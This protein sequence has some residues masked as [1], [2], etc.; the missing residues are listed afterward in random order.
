MGTL[1]GNFCA[2]KHD[3]HCSAG[4]ILN[5]NGLS[6]GEM[7]P[8]SYLGLQA[9]GTQGKCAQKCYESDQ[10]THERS[11]FKSK[12]FY[13]LWKGFAWGFA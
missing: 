7:T 12:K 8:V 13:G 4:Y 5:L 2:I 9:L 6:S 1:R 11:F 10:S 3:S